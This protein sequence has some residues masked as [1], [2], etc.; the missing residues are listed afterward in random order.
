MEEKVRTIW[1]V[2][3]TVRAQNRK[4]IAIKKLKKLGS[5]NYYHHKGFFSM[6]PLALV[7]AEYIFLW[8]DCG[9]SGSCSNAQIFNR[10]DF[11]DKI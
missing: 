10:S 4:H 7:D 5:G 2:L 3:P 8:T 1:N 11:G 9:P 6:V